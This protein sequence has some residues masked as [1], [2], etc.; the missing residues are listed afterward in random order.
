M[1]SGLASEPNTKGVVATTGSLNSTVSA[2]GN[3]VSGLASE[4]NT[5]GVVTTTGSLN[6]TVSANNGNAVVSTNPP[7]NVVIALPKK[8]TKS[9]SD[10]GGRQKVDSKPEEV[11]V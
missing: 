3:A 10:L 2:N 4:P 7:V 1:V 5:K 6:S 8:V 9:V 11:L